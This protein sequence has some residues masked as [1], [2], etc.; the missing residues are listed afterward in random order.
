MDNN[1]APKFDPETGRPLTPPPA[2]PEQPTPQFDPETGRPLGANPE[3]QR[4]DSQPHPYVQTPPP[5]EPQA[6]QPKPKADG[7][8]I[9]SLI[10][11][12]AA[13]ICCCCTYLALAVGIAAVV[14]AVLSKKQQGKFSGMALG[15]MI[16]GIIGGGFALISIILGIV[17]STNGLLTDLINEFS[18]NHGFYDIEPDYGIYDFFE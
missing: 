11:G 17:M 15:G 8:A 18:P 9:A 2:Q 6:E 13:L 10:C 14:L 12:I 3:P 5:V 16:C 1:Q 7:L 4:L